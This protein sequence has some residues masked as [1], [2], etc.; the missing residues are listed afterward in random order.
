[1]AIAAAMVKTLD[2]A[3]VGPALVHQS[4]LLLR[5]KRGIG[6]SAFFCGSRVQNYVK[7]FWS[8]WR[9]C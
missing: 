5:Q 2:S 6:L 1:M 7:K 8:L 3:S 9:R 4:F